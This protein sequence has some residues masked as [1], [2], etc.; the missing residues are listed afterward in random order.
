M[1][2]KDGSAIITEHTVTEIVDDS[3]QRTGLVRVVRD[4]TERKRAEEELTKHR[5]HL[6]ELVEERT[7]ELQVEVS[8]RR[9][10]EQALRESEEQYRA[11]FE[12]AA[13]SIVLIDAETGAFV[14]FNDRAHQALGY[15]RQEFEKRRISDFDVIQAPEEVAKHIRKIIEEGAETFETK[16]RTKDGDIRDI[17][18]SARAISLRGRHFI[19][20]IW[21]D[22]SER[23]RAEKALRESEE[24]FRGLAE[25]TFEGLA[26]HDKGRIIDANQTYASMF[27]YEPSEVIGMHA[28]DFAAPESRDLVQQRLLSGSKEPFEAVGLRKDGSTFAGEVWGRVLPYRGRMITVTAVR[29][30]SERKRA[31]EALQRAREEIESR[32]ERRVQQVNGYGLTFR[33]LTVLH[34]VAAGESDKEIASVLGISPLTVHKHIANILGKMGASCRTEA[35]VRALREGLLE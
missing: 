9:R 5:E 24:R 16:H 15:S 25:A 14:E 21:R 6:A 29:D 8:E 4:V 31:E 13:D 10:A 33:E 35:G 3:G 23:R 22:V 12:Q 7:A 2:R 20:G 28:L 27:G 34:L 19:Q 30:V 11:I 1:R 17:Q 32:V 26:I 18:V